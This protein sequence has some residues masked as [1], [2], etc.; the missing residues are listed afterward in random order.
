MSEVNM[1]LLEKIDHWLHGFRLKKQARRLQAITTEIENYIAGGA[2]DK[3]LY[4]S[5][6]AMSLLF[7]IDKDFRRNIKDFSARYV[8][9]SRDNSIDVSAIFGKKRILFTR[10]DAMT[11]KDSEV[12]DPISMVIF[13]DAKSMVKFLLSGDPD[14]LQGILNNQLSV[15]GNLNY[16]FKFVYML[17][18]IPEM[19]GITGFKQMVQKTM[20]QNHSG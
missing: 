14:V 17:M 9:K 12:K 15:S 10:M 20:A 19:L 3:V 6:K 16:L 5:L 18:L 1:K 13:H 11:V 8:I 2:L 7:W 4:L